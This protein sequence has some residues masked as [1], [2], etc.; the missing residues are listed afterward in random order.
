LQ[1]GSMLLRACSDER[2]TA[3]H[4]LAVSAPRYPAGGPRWQLPVVRAACRPHQVI[5]GSIP[6]QRSRLQL[7][8][9]DARCA[10]AARAVD[11]RA[12]HVI[13]ALLWRQRLRTPRRARTVC[14][15]VMHTRRLQITGEPEFSKRTKAGPTHGCRA[16]CHPT[17][18]CRE[19]AATEAP[20]ACGSAGS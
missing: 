6:L 9:V 7:V 2:L 10:R 13:V 18:A 12:A 14:R 17:Q 20:S 16:Q 5:H 3:L 8:E 19:P 4:R 15:R 11:A 1:P